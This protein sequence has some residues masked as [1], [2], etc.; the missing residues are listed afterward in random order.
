MLETCLLIALVLFAEIG[1][2]W[3]NPNRHPSL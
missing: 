3:L 2:A 1:E